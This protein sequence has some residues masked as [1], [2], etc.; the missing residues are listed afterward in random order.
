MNAHS[1]TW[2][3][4]PT[5]S[6]RSSPLFPAAQNKAT[7]QAASIPA[8]G[9]TAIFQNLIKVTHDGE[10]GFQHAAAQVHD[11]ALRDE[12]HKY[13]RERRSMASEL[14]QLMNL[15]GEDIA[16]P[17]GSA[18]AAFHRTWMSL[19]TALSGEPNDQAILDE[20][21]R[22]EEA[23][24][25]A[26]HEVLDP[27]DLLPEA[28]RSGIETLAQKVHRAHE[29]VRRLRDSGLYQRPHRGV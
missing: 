11:R 5:P 8:V 29:R 27:N 6:A 26:F 24:E 14:T 12:F 16:R 1:Q 17:S 19:R 20:V 15:V 25:E 9:L 28:V 22:G 18:T 23:A 21:E 2:P 13:A 10:H 7:Q 4:E 3:P